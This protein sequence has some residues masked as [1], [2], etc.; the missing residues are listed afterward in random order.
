MKTWGK[1]NLL[2]FT[3]LDGTLLDHDSYSYQEAK[4]SDKNASF[5]NRYR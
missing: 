5:A 1:I 4:A 2:A 3:D